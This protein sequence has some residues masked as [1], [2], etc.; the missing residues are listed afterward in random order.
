MSFFFYC[1]MEESL[2]F[3]FLVLTVHLARVEQEL[4]PQHAFVLTKWINFL[5]CECK[6]H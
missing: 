4:V 3:K 5:T 6:G 2:H 1:L